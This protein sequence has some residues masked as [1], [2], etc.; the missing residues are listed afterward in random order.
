M[1]G[2]PW[3]PTF[4]QMLPGTA[5]RYDGR[6]VDAS[7]S[8]Q[9]GAYNL[10]SLPHHL[11]FSPDEYNGENPVV[12][13]RDYSLLS[14]GN[15]LNAEIFAASFGDKWASH[16]SSSIL[17]TAFLWWWKSQSTFNGG[18]PRILYKSDLLENDFG[19]QTGRRWWL[20]AGVAHQDGRFGF[21]NGLGPPET[22]RN[23]SLNWSLWQA[24][25][26]PVSLGGTPTLWIRDSSAYPLYGREVI[27]IN[28]IKHGSRLVSPID[29]NRR[30]RLDDYLPWL[31]L[32]ENQPAAPGP[33]VYLEPWY[34]NTP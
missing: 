10:I 9:H 21:T 23:W 31:V 13:T 7:D 2:S 30:F 5:T 19:E 34:R 17:N 22:N 1:I 24:D 29:L 18:L 20:A 3:N 33:P 8:R 4:S 15:R 16:E 28:D 26:G 27:P 25:D 12:L 32:S 11:R 14:S 6:R